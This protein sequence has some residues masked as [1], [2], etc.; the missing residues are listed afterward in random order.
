MKDPHGW[1]RT[2]VV[3][4]GSSQED[5]NILN[6]M[7][8]IY[9]GLPTFVLIYLYSELDGDDSASLSTR[10]GEFGFR[11]DRINLKLGIFAVLKMARKVLFTFAHFLRK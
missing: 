8:F 3:C 6:K 2:A 5:L 9:G 4:G 1:E 7:I 10:W 11:A